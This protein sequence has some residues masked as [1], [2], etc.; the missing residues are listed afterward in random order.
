MKAKTK[1]PLTCIS[2]GPMIGA[3]T[4]GKKLVFTPPA[5]MMEYPFIVAFMADEE[6]GQMILAY[7]RLG[8]MRD[9]RKSTITA[10]CRS[11]DKEGADYVRQIKN[12]R[13]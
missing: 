9:F 2:S 6:C 12:L 5:K 13:K 3:M 4:G 7:S 1:T 10:V 11:L 8:Y